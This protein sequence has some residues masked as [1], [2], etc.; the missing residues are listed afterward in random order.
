MRIVVTGAAGFIGSHLM[1]ALDADGHQ[2]VGIDNLTTGRLDNRPDVQIGDV[3]DRLYLYDLANN[4]RPELVIHCAASYSDPNKW[5]FDTKTNVEGGINAALVA[6]HHNARLI[7]FQTILPPISSYA[8]S[9]IASEQYQRL[10]GVPLIVFRLAN[11]YGPRNRSGPVPVFYNRLTAGK[12]CT[13]VDTGRDMVFIHDLIRCVLRGINEDLTGTFD[14]CTGI[15]TPIIDIFRSVS[16]AVGIHQEPPIVPPGD[17]DVQGTISPD[18]R[19]HDWEAMI[20]LQT[21]IATTVASYQEFG[22]G[23][24]YTHLALKG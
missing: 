7:Y 22:V 20:D 4:L 16:A 15:E 17:D 8:I 11:I 12:P 19:L 18:N 21:G 2:L 1:D 13:V 3:T 23:E 14:V 9:K 6:R 5:H 10:S 24:T